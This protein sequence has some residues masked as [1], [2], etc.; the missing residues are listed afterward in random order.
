MLVVVFMSWESSYEK[1]CCDRIIE[2]LVW[3]KAFLLNLHDEVGT[4]HF[5]SYHYVVK[6]IYDVIFSITLNFFLPFACFNQGHDLGNDSF[7]NI[8]ICT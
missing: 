1:K 7:L 2:L 6:I 5:F 8:E 4:Y 3:E